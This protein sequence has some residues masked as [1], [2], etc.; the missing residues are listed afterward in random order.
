MQPPADIQRAG[1]RGRERTQ[2]AEIGGQRERAGGM[3]RLVQ[4]RRELHRQTR[5]N[6]SPDTGKKDQQHPDR[7]DQP[8]TPTHDTPLAAGRQ[9]AV[10]TPE[11]VHPTT[12]QPTRL[13]AAGRPADGAG[14]R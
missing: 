14:T 3:R 13:W 6:D 12:R 9:T 4:V 11:G 5:N 10:N 2:I 1:R 8:G 7:D